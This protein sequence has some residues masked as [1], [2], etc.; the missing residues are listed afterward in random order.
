MLWYNE[1]ME[2]LMV[3]LL[4]LNL[5]AILFGIYYF[6][7]RCQTK[8][9]DTSE[10]EIKIVKTEGKIEL[11]SKKIEEL[12]P[13]IS[14]EFRKNRKELNENFE[15]IQVSNEKKLE[16]MR[17]TVDEKLQKSVERRFNES[18]TKISQ[19]LTQVYQGLGEM[20]S[21]ASGVGDLKKVME[22]VKTRGVYGEVQLGLIIEDMLAPSQYLTNTL[23]KK[24]SLDRVEFAVRLPGKD[25]EVLLPIDSKFPIENYQRL[26]SAYDEGDKDKIEKARKELAKDVKTQAKKICDKYI[27]IPKT[28]A[29]GLMFV[30][31][32]SLYAEIIRIPGLDDTIRKKYNISICGPSTL[33]VVLSG[34]LMGYRTIAI[35]KRSA[36]VWKVLES[37]K[38]QFGKFGDLLDGVERKLNESAKKIGAAKAQS[39][40]I[41]NTMNEVGE[42]PEKEAEK[43][44]RIEF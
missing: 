34:L 13:I 29:F 42:L 14:D 19:Q 8:K 33:P 39:K 9:V 26:L 38:A 35:E 2:I 28:T 6:S 12:G 25:A 40:K 30:P 41:E 43:V 44:L 21:L 24:G 36:E 4:V 15:K 27:E 17:E 37:V 10:L 32:E 20:K 11:L 18:F 16:Q 1:F 5:V 31:T 23:I 7:T 3:I 22:G